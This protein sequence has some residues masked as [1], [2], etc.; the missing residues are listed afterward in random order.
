[1]RG[2]VKGVEGARRVCIA[3]RRSVAKQAKAAGLGDPAAFFNW[4]WGRR[5][6]RR[7]QGMWRRWAACCLVVSPRRS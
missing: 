6:Y 2:K 3:L 7:D 5:D 4:G 1:M